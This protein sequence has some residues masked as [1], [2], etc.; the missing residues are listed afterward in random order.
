MSIATL[1]GV[2]K[3]FGVVTALDDVTFAVE[4]GDV[5][6]LLGRNGAG[7]STA[8]AVLL[9][10]RCPDSGVARL[11]GSDPRRTDARRE[12]GV[13]PRRRPFRRRC[14]SAS[15]STSSVPTTSTRCRPRQS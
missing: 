15:W 1:A 8:L 3:R 13:T 4:G 7:K 11:L 14:A 10:L 6:A 5:V 12:V 2:T 9:G